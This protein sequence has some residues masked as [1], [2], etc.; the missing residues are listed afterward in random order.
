MHTVLSSSSS[1]E[2][3]SPKLTSGFKL[4]VPKPPG[5][6]EPS[7]SSDDS[8]SEEHNRPQVS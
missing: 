1:V 2:S 4:S 5:I 8:E 3:P 7:S 6:I